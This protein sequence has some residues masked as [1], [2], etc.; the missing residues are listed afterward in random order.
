MDTDDGLAPCTSGEAI[1]YLL[2]ERDSNSMSARRRRPCPTNAFY[3]RV[4]VRAARD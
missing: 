1:R 3:A 2:N 4:R